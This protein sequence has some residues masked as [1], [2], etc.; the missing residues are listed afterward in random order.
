MMDKRDE[1]V[2]EVERLMECMTRWAD[3]FDREAKNE[4]G[5]WMDFTD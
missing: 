3:Y 2:A 1:L 5:T 4:R